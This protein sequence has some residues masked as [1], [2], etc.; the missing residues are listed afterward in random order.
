[1]CS[2][3]KRKKRKRKNTEYLRR[4]SVLFRQLCVTESNR[5]MNI[6]IL[7]SYCKNCKFE[8]KIS[9]VLK[10]SHS[11]HITFFVV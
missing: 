6:G 3:S 9:Y 5:L 7:I 2:K 1:M 8:C 4:K 10:I 11:K